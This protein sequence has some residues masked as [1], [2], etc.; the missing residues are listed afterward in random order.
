MTAAAAVH[1][2][3]LPA[4]RP[5]MG[6]LV[7]VELRKMTDTRAGFWLQLSV[8][9]LTIAVAVLSAILG[10][11]DDHTLRNIFGNAIQPVVVL[12]P[13]VGVLLVSSEWSQRTALISFTLVPQRSRVLVAKLWAS[14]V[15]AA[16]AVGVSLVVS[17]V[18]TALASP[19][20]DNTWTLPAAAL[21]QIA[22][23][24]GASMV[25]GVAFGAALLS[26]APAI[27]LLFA[28]P[29]PLLALGALPALEDAAKWLDQSRSFEPLTSHVMDGTEWARVGTTVIL[30]V[31][32]PL[33]IGMWRIARNEIR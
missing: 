2:A 10:H 6:R 32:V 19:G 7:G 30:W 12:L 16:V 4:T 5:G 15:L 18:A 1:P 25:M 23:Y 24:V 14:L 3:R 26:T 17:V 9:G 33:L 28:L 21:G 11:A 27:V 13:V 8:V 22:V 31:L 29:I 20:V